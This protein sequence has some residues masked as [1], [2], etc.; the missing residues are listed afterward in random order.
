LK[1]ITPDYSVY[2][3]GFVGYGIAGNG[4]VFYILYNG[5][6]GLEELWR[7]DGTAAGTVMLTSAVSPYDYLNV[8]GNTAFFAAGDATYGYEL[9]ESDGTV[10]GTKMVKDINSGSGSSD[11]GGMFVFNNEVYF[12]AYDGNNHAFWKSDG[13]KS[14]TIKLRNGD[15]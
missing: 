14:G 13:K 7:T 9:W 12:G 3:Y 6:T 10:G 11:P 15:P 5:F 8:A 2:Y 4:L 1:K